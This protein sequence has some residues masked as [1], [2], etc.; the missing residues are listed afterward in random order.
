[1]ELFV[2]GLVASVPLAIVA[3]LLTPRVATAL[4]E[5]NAERREERIR[6]LRREYAQVTAYR[7]GTSNM[8][9]ARIMSRIL[10]AL[11]LFAFAVIF[12]LVTV[13][14]TLSQ[15]P[16]PSSALALCAVC[17]VASVAL[18]TYES[19]SAGN[20][21]GKVYQPR[22]YEERTVYELGKLG[23]SL[24][25]DDSAAAPETADEGG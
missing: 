12:N 3:N 10:R 9:A 1:V 6:R 17:G 4:A 16:F 24:E 15:A 8:M 13:V 23:A 22:L 21:C 25:P 5:R 7:N 11:A 19:I 2:L 20:L 14:A 18:A